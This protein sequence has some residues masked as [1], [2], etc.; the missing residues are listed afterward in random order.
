MINKP[1]TSNLPKLRGF[2]KSLKT[3]VPRKRLPQKLF[4]PVH[5]FEGLDFPVQVRQFTFPRMKPRWTNGRLM[6]NR[7]SVENG[8][9]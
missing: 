4:V 2:P 6:T 3:E 9:S 5:S 8:M 1:F 7:K